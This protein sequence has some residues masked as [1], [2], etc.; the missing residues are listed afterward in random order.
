MVRWVSSSSN[1][2]QSGNC[3]AYPWYFVHS[4]VSQV[5]DLEDRRETSLSYIFEDDGGVMFS[6][7]KQ[8][9]Q[10]FLLTYYREKLTVDF[11]CSRQHCFL[12]ENLFLWQRNGYCLNWVH[13]QANVSRTQRVKWLTDVEREKVQIEVLAK[14]FGTLLMVQEPQTQPRRRTTKRR[15]AK[16]SEA[17]LEGNFSSASF[18]LTQLQ[19]RIL[20]T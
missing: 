7:V 15:R 13:G 11:S 18:R 3:V 1:W 12:P 5:V 4:F 2:K 8:P 19:M 9:H 6:L 10:L 20:R 17:F 14:Y 16:L